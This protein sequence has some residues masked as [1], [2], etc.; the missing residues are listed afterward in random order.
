MPPLWTIATSVA[1]VFK[2]LPNGK[3]DTLKAMYG[4]MRG[5]LA[6]DRATAL[7]F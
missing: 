1:T 3:A 5:I 7:T 6:S 4:Q 2:I